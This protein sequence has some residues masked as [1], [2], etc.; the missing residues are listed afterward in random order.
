MEANSCV[1]DTNQLTPPIQTE[2]TGLNQ[3]NSTLKLQTRSF[4]LF[5]LKLPRRYS[6]LRQ[7]ILEMP[8][9]V[10]VQ[11]YQGWV[12]ALLKLM[13]FCGGGETPSQ[14]CISNFPEVGL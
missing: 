2:Q 14:P 13:N 1:E 4:K 12:G 8:D 10:G 5:A 9:Q 6:M 7:L 3:P 11:A